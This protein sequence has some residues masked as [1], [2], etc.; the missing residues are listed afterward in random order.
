MLGMPIMS[1]S[2]EASSLQLTLPLLCAPRGDANNLEAG[3]SS[4]RSRY[5]ER[6]EKVKNKVFIWTQESTVE[7]RGGRKE[8][9]VG[10][11][12]I[13]LK[14]QIWGM[15]TIEG[16]TERNTGEQREG[17]GGSKVNLD[18]GMTVMTFWQKWKHSWVAGMADRDKTMSKVDQNSVWK[19]MVCTHMK[20]RPGIYSSN[21]VSTEALQS[22]PL[23][24]C[25]K[26]FWSGLYESCWL[27]FTCC[28]TKVQP[29]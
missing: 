26:T 7:W 24:E 29:L 8:C 28:P 15:Q 3:I 18:Q 12:E 14:S 9:K 16:E 2:W 5:R 17:R 21:K 25:L 19:F 6:G 23:Q 13:Y 11:R 4:E 22:A 27:M 10:R 1:F 20:F